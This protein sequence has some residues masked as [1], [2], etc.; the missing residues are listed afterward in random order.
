MAKHARRKTYIN[1]HG[2]LV[3]FKINWWELAA[4]ISVGVGLATVIVIAVMM[5]TD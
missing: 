2:Q 5:A 4:Q 1:A 3:R